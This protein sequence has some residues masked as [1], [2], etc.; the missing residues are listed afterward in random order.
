MKDHSESET[1]LLT[2]AEIAEALGV[3]AST[4]RRW[5]GSGDLRAVRVGG[6]WRVP[7][8]AFARWV[9]FDQPRVAV[10]PGYPSATGSRS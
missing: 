6:Q 4:V 1:V 7:R 8:E 2:T 9:T 10:Q 3:T 5:I